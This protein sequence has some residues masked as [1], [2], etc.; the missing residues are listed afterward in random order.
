MEVV[1]VEGGEEDGEKDGEKDG[2]KDGEKDGE[3]DGKKEE[4]KEEAMDNNDGG[5]GGS[6]EHVYIF[7]GSSMSEDLN[8]LYRIV[9]PRLPSL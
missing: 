5:S 3:K 8:D 2:K 4:E 1:V 6:V 9:V 7:G